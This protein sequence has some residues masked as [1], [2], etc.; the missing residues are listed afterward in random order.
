MSSGAT[1]SKVGLVAPIIRDEITGAYTIE[2]GPYMLANGGVFCLDEANEISKDDAKYIGECME[3]GECHITKAVNVI[4]KTEAPLLAALIL[5]ME[6]MI[7]K[8]L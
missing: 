1:S 2:P 6:Y 4:V 8:S 5:M 3:N 7:Q